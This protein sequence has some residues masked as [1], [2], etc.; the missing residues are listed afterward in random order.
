MESVGFPV[1]A[2]V[3]DMNPANISL[4]NSLSI[5]TENPS[6]ENPSAS[7]REIH[8]FADA[9]HL[10]KLVRNNFLD[11]GFELENGNFVQSGCVKEIIQRSLSDLKPT[12]RLTEKHIH[13]TG[14]QRMNVRKAAQL[15]SETTSK[16]LDFYGRQG[17]LLSMY[18]KSTRDFIK[19][20]DSWFDVFNSRVPFDRKKQKKL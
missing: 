14:T 16:A 9:P 10:I 17:L 5:G 15:L 18:W 13:V 12:Y 7:D 3:R 20:V 2:I 19:L 4:W 11:S 8:V 6:F 1:V